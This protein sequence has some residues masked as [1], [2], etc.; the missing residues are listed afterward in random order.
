MPLED[1]PS[2]VCSL[3]PSFLRLKRYAPPSLH[4]PIERRAIPEGTLSVS[5]LSPLWR[6]CTA[7][8]P[9]GCRSSVYRANMGP[10]N[11]VPKTIRLSS[12]WGYDSSLLP[13]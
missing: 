11:G 1:L 10:S 5:V 2:V 13:P 9:I 12:L 6:P 7:A 3:H 8:R 4:Y